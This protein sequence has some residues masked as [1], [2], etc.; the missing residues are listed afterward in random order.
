[1]LGFACTVGAVAALGVPIT[2]VS[3][4]NPALVAAAAVLAGA[5]FGFLSGYTA[6]VLTGRRGGSGSKDPV[7][8]TAA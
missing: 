4:S 6:T 1:V 2:Q 3:M 8:E 5:A 7:G